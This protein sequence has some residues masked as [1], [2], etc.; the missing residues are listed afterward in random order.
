MKYAAGNIPGGLSQVDPPVQTPL[1]R[2]VHTRHTA[3]ERPCLHAVSTAAEIP[4]G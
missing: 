4:P 2:S 1:L 3:A